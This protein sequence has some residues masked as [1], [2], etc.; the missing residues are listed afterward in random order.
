[1]KRKFKKIILPILLICLLL[2]VFAIVGYFLLA[3]YYRQGFALNTWINGVYCT[4]KSVEAVNSE[5]LL[6]IEA[7]IVIITDKE[8][9]KY[10][11]SLAEADYQEDY[12]TS[13]HN[14]ME[15]QNPYL[16]ID[17]VTF[18]RNHELV[19]QKSYDVTR[20][21]EIFYELAPIQEEMQKQPDLSLAWDDVSES[22]QLYDSL[23]GRMDVEKVFDTVV[24]AIAAGEYQIDLQKLDCYYDIPLTKAQERT[25]VLWEK[26]NHF[27]TCDL[28]Y[29]MGAEKIEF[30]PKIMCQFLTLDEKNSNLPVLDENG[31]FMLNQEA[32]ADFVK[33]LAYEYDTY[34]IDRQFHSTRGDVV[35]LTKGN[36]GTTLNQEAE[37][38]YL[39]DTLLSPEIHTGV[40]KEHI[41]QYVKE[42]F[43][44]GKNDIGSTYIEVDMTEQKL[45]YY[46]NSELKIETDVVTGNM[47]RKMGTPSGIY[48]V[49][50]KQTN[51]V[52]RG[53][54]YA[55]PVDYWMPVKGGIGIHDADWRDEFG[56]EIYKTNGSHGCINVP[57]EVMS[58]LYE[59]VEI[60]TPVIMF[61]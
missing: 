60:G 15:E 55:S 34:G 37:I 12:L 41:P 54:G 32:V 11:I 6:G 42:A 27:Q 13:L 50:N 46:E 30:T 44:R 47:R 20:L 57:T 49:Y 59:L 29:D 36:Y 23:S 4:G 52:L 43:V 56:G 24:A 21:K 25:K 5:L 53:P 58:Q 35:T 28:V 40:T 19:P 14:Y 3:F 38:T 16:W 17:N 18:H 33:S 22:Y 8:G 45:Y 7:P 1:M 61:Y 51:R 39:L 26:I 9:L 2:F 48:S 31:D 10:Q